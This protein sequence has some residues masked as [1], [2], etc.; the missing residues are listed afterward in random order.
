MDFVGEKTD[1]FEKNF[2]LNL[3]SGPKP[4][5]HVFGN[6]T[7]IVIFNIAS[8]FFFFFFLKQLLEYIGNIF[9]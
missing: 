8:R 1:T 7:V 6:C 5:R 9:L 3:L 2:I 4:S